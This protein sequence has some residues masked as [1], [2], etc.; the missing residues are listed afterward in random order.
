[1]TVSPDGKMLLYVQPDP[2]GTDIM[3]VDNFR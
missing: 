2:G 3:I 1:M